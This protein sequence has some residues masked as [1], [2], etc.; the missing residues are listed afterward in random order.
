MFI[1]NDNLYIPHLI[2]VAII[3]YQF[4]TIHPFL[5]G[6]GRIGRL[7]IPLYLLSK[8]VLDK[9]C[10]YI[11]DYFEKHRTEYYDALHRARI[12]NDILGWINF[13]LEATIHTAQSAKIKFKR[14]VEVVESYKRDIFAIQGNSANN[15]RI[16]ETFFD[17]PYQNGKM[18]QQKT[19][20]NQPT[21]DRS[22]RI[23]LEKGFLIE[24]TG[25]SRN[26]MFALAK[27]VDIFKN[28]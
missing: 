4:E 12:N 10:F 16:V 19:E 5:D 3:H 6:N 1:N 13:F 24:T 21:I 9:P 7:L 28:V 14:V 25:F 20:I 22:L 8:K 26:R 18:I 17:D 23:M 27:Y 11:S 2:K 15:M